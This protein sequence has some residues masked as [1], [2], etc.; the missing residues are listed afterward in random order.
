MAESPKM[1]QQSQIKIS[2]ITMTTQ[3]PNCLLN[4][5]NIGKY[6]KIDHEVIGLKYNYAELNVTKGTYS[7]TIYKKAKIKDINKINKALFYNQTTLILN[8]RGNHVNVKLFGNGSMHMTGC[9]SEKEGT[10]VTQLLYQKLQSLRGQVDTVFL[11]KDIHGVLLDKDNLI[12]SYNKKQIIG[13]VKEKHTYVINKRE[14]EIDAKTGMFIAK[15]AET[16]RR[17]M[18]LNFDGECIGHCRIEM[19]KN[20]NKFYKRNNN[21]YYDTANGLIFYNNNLIIGKF[22]YEVDSSQHTNISS[23]P[24]VLE[25]EYQCDPFVNR[26]Y[27]LDVNT[28][29]TELTTRIDQ[30]VNC[31]NV[32]FNLNYRLNRSRFYE[33]LI[34][35]GF[36][37]KY[38]PESYSGIKLIYK[39]P[40]NQSLSE[41]TG[42]CLCNSKCTCRNIT[43]LIFQSGNVI[44][45]G[46]RSEQQ[47]NT[48]CDKFFSLCKRFECTIRCRD[49]L[50]CGV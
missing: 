12:Y 23:V 36:I 7:T 50:H 15:K 17:R 27:T 44:A 45:T 9:K 48:I 22:Q 20:K 40:L 16:Q 18:I 1:S 49:E 10:E 47:I 28:N 19:M 13:Y 37:C 46:F 24:D 42:K 26:A 21:L 14:Y 29:L 5:T 3:F 6:L 8:N 33:I 25:W 32:Y 31:I 38:K 11:T 30:N 35:E 39:Q 4:L 2:T 43:F 41:G 34:Q